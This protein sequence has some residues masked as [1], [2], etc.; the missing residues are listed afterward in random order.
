MI[1]LEKISYRVYNNYDCFIYKGYPNMTYNRFRFIFIVFFLL[2]FFVFFNSGVASTV[3]ISYSYDSF[4]HIENYGARCAPTATMNNFIYLS[5]QYS[6]VYSSTDIIPDWNDNGIVTDDYTTSRDYLFAGWTGPN[7]YRE[8]MD[9]AFGYRWWEYRAYW[10]DDFAPGVTLVSGQ[11]IDDTNMD[12]VPFGYLVEPVYPTWDYLWA[13]MSN[14]LVVE[15]GILSEYVEAAHA[16]SLCSISFDDINEDGLWQDGEQR[17][18]GFID[19]NDPYQVTYREVDNNPVNDGRM[20]I[21]FWFEEDFGIV[22]AF[23]QG[24]VP[25]PAS[26]VLVL[27]SLI[28][29]FVRRKRL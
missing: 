19:P 13:C 23:A 26:F 4:G 12:T 2:Y 7:G 20:E 14:G 11:Y 17:E 28:G 27:S 16:V 8:G 21:E 22:L 15:L 29:F 5:N 9:P 18:I 25:E 6:S 10:L 24:P 3:S 1:I